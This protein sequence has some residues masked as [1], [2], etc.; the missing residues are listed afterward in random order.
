MIQM[1][2]SFMNNH[3]SILSSEFV[4]CRLTHDKCRDNFFALYDTWQNLYSHRTCT[5]SSL[6]S[7]CAAFLFLIVVT[8]SLRPNRPKCRKV[9][10]CSSWSR[11][12]MNVRGSDAD[13]GRRKMWFI[14][15]RRQ[16]FS[17]RHG[18]RMRIYPFFSSFFCLGTH[19]TIK[20]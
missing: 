18:R 19:L 11:L 17:A 16:H 10:R 2:V 6:S 12:R 9:T 15:D 13:G 1:W 5:D 4:S 20:L 3:N 8:R 7:R 14:S